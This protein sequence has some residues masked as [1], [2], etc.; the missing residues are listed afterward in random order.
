MRF[1]TP[2]AAC[3]VFLHSPPWKSL[4]MSDIEV[5]QRVSWQSDVLRQW[6]YLRCRLFVCFASLA[7]LVWRPW[8]TAATSG[9]VTPKTRAA[10]ARIVRPRSRYLLVVCRRYSGVPHE[11]NRC[12]A[13]AATCRCET[14]RQC[15][16]SRRQHSLLV[17]TRLIWLFAIAGGTANTRHPQDVSNRTPYVHLRPSTWAYAQFLVDGSYRRSRLIGVCV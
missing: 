15:D 16:I 4:S 12:S 10:A 17:D 11:G 1:T 13:L 2:A 3:A 8:R 14:R 5:F 7:L 6:V 9:A